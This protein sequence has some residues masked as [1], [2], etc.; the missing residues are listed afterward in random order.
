MS[1]RRSA[2]ALLLV[3][4]AGFS[5]AE[6]TVILSA[7][8]IVSATAAPQIQEYLENARQIKAEGDVNVIAL[9]LIR[10]ITNVGH[11]GTAPEAAPDLLVSAGEIPETDDARTRAWS[12]PADDRSTQLLDDHLLSNAAGY[13][14][15]TRDGF[16]WHGPY[17][18]R[19]SP[20]PWGSRYEANVG[21]L[22]QPGGKAVV[23]VSAGPNRVIETPF[24]QVG[25]TPAGD[26]IVALVGRGQ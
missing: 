18:D 4:A 19:L 24:E 12:A 1:V 26:D 6:T 7:T 13:P 2:A 11:L 23:V 17:L 20:D 15:A 21:L 3:S 14:A 8:S 9:S 5:A 22:H 25:L 16:G 10:L